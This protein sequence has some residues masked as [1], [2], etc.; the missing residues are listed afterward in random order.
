LMGLRRRTRR[1]IEFPRWCRRLARATGP[2]HT[3][4]RTAV[5]LGAGISSPLGLHQPGASAAGSNWRAAGSGVLTE[6]PHSWIGDATHALSEATK[7]GAGRPR[8]GAN[9]PE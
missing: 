5:Q 4:L 8:A 7:A 3:H 9:H 1:V 2:A 6:G